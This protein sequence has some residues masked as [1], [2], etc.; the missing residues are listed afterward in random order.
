MSTFWI[1]ILIG[2]VCGSTVTC[3][4]LAAEWIMDRFFND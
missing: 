4:V 3:L 1:L 2:V